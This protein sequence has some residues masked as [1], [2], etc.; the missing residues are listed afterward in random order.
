VSLL[1]FKQ[2]LSKYMPEASLPFGPMWLRKF[3]SERWENKSV[4]FFSEDI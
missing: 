4:G 1:K 2:A 3:A